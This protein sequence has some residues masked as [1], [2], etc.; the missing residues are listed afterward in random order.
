MACISGSFASG[1]SAIE[2][3][4]QPLS[5]TWSRTSSHMGSV[6]SSPSDSSTKLHRWSATPR[7][8]SSAAAASMPAPIEVFPDGVSA[9]MS[10]CM[11][12]RCVPASMRSSCSR[13]SAVD[14]KRT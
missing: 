12:V 5:V 9:A 2:W 6:F 11:S 1:P 3:M 14:E 13:N 4:A 10:A 7:A 8:S